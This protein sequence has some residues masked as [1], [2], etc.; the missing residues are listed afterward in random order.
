MLIMFIDIGNTWTQLS[1]LNSINL[2]RRHVLPPDNNLCVSGCGIIETADH[3]FVGSNFFEKVWSLICHWIGI[4]FVCSRSIND[5]FLQFIYLA[6]MSRSSYIYSKVIWLASA[7]AI[8]KD[9]NNRVF[10]NVVI[11]PLNILEKAKLNFFLWFSS[12]F[13]PIAFG[14]YDWWRHPFLCMGV[15]QFCFY[16]LG[17]GILWFGVMFL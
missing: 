2:I 15:M 11:N 17:G 5:H 6:G 1:Y 8:C 7:W 9:R 10:I 4:S 16:F 13:V 14:F 12:N 3:L